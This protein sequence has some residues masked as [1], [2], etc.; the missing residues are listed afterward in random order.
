MTLGDN[1]NWPPFS[2]MVKKTSISQELEKLET[3]S[4]FE[5]RDTYKSYPLN[6]EL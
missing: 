3:S 4:K 2:C 1:F 5:K 6:C